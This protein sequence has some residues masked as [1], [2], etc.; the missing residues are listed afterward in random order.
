MGCPVV[1][2]A[3]HEL[4]YGLGLWCVSLMGVALVVYAMTDFCL[5]TLLARVGSI[6]GE[7]CRRGAD[8]AG[9]VYDGRSYILLC[10]S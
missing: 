4:I 8:I 6:D 7:D 9:C 5:V 3:R 2:L 10:Q 1:T